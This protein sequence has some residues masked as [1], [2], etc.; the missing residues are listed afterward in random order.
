MILPKTFKRWFL[1]PENVWKRPWRFQNIGFLGEKRP[2]KFQRPKVVITFDTEKS[3]ESINL[4]GLESDMKLRF[5]QELL[6]RRLFHH[7]HEVALND[8]IVCPTYFHQAQDSCAI[9]IYQRHER[10][11]NNIYQGISFKTTLD[12]WAFCMFYEAFSG[13]YRPYVTLIS[14]NNF[15]PLKLFRSF[16]T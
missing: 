4:T 11:F 6:F 8:R 1:S 13:S 14:D 16:F 15:W 3:R 5:I 10:T 9:F 2:K 7:V 12:L